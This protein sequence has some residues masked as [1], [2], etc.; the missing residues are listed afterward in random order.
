MSQNLKKYLLFLLV[1][2]SFSACHKTEKIAEEI[3][4]DSRTPVTVTSVNEGEMQDF[5]ELNATSAFL[6]KSFV[7]AT[8]NGYLQ[9]VSTKLGEFVAVNKVLFTLKT[10]ETQ[11]L[12][13][14][15][16]GLDSTFKFSGIT[17]ISATQSGYIMQLNHQNGDY[18]QDGEQLAAINE[19]NSFV[20]LLDLPYEL[21]PYILNQKSVKL[22]MPD[23]EILMGTIVQMMPTVDA[24]SQTE[25]V[26][27]KVNA[28]HQ[29]PEN[30][31]AKVRIVKKTK[32]NAIS[33]PKKAILT[34]ETQSNFWVM[35]M[36]N[37]STAVKIPIQKGIE[38]GGRVE[39]LSPKF[40]LRD[41]ILVSGN[42]GLPDT[43]SVKIEKAN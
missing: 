20:F 25:S 28:N 26:A 21:R 5:L 36:I 41:K 38:L 8:S 32:T 19:I 16:N 9:S 23:G 37:A 1:F 18:V 40:Q 10:K 11:G 7:K 33:L 29:I 2:I 30:L 6:Q 4:V 22:T 43:A 34:D 42:Y 31:I 3:P 27:I 12:G 35:K 17:K 13:N 14:I 15:L 39:I 24:I